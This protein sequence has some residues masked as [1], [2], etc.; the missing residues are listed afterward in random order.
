MYHSFSRLS[1]GFF[2]H[3]YYGGY[4]TMAIGLVLI[5]VI[6]YL[7]IKKRI[8]GS[9]EGIETPLDVLMKRYVNG[10]ISKEEFLEKKEI[11]RK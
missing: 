8:P 1:D 10:E 2:G 6:G 11:L 3:S 5:L 7:L 9:A 4:I